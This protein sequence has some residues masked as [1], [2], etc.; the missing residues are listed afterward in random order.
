MRDAIAWSYDLLTTDE[1]ALFRRLAVFAGGWTLDAAEAVA[2]GEG[3]DEW[4]LISLLGE[5]IEKSLVVAETPDG[6]GP[7][8]GEPR[9]RLLEPVRQFALE[10]LERLD[11]GRRAAASMLRTSSTSPRASRRRMPGGNSSLG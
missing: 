11:E 8:G 1:Q 10:Q 6:D 9:Y 7:G 4:D 5:L 3:L 2:G